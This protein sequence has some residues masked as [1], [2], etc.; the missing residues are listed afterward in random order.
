VNPSKT[1]FSLRNTSHGFADEL[2]PTGL[3]GCCCKSDS[4]LECAKVDRPQVENRELALS[5][6]KNGGQPAPKN[7]IW[8]PLLIPISGGLYST[9]RRDSPESPSDEAAD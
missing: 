2:P 8:I 1:R 6:A 5:N 9:T 3:M 7:G 4:K